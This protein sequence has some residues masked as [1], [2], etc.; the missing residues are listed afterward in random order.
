MSVSSDKSI[1]IH[2][3]ETTEIIQK[4]ERA[5]NKGVIDAVWIDENMIV[6][7]STDNTV[8][9]WNVEDGSEIKSLQISEDGTEKVE[10]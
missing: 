6:S 7:C 10:N 9:F 2:D 1:V 5:H 3:S 4:I 8:K